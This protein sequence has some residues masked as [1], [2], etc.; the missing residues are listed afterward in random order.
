[1]SNMLKNMS[2]MSNNM[3]NMSNNMSNMLK[4]ISNNGTNTLS[5]VSFGCRAIIVSF[6]ETIAIS[7]LIFYVFVLYIM[8]RTKQIRR[9]P[10]YQL[11]IHMGFVHVIFI[12]IYI[13]Y[14]GPK[15]LLAPMDTFW[16]EAPIS[17]IWIL[18]AITTTTML[19]AIAF[20]R[21]A[22][23]C[24]STLYEIFL[25]FVHFSSRKI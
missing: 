5:Q 3:S 16:F 11:L 8:C 18:S 24:Q 23:I 14:G 4:N 25:Y 2:K 1:M 10:F 19:P 20:N 9:Q 7:L 6:S 13:F 21:Y 22:A 15:T 12:A 17:F